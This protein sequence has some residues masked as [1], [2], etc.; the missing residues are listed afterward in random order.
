MQKQ[1]RQGNR[2]L[3]S[4]KKKTNTLVLVVFLGGVSLAFVM[5]FGGLMPSSAIIDDE[6]LRT[7]LESSPPERLAMTDAIEFFDRRLEKN[8]RDPVPLNELVSS[9]FLRFK[10]YGRIQDLRLAK[11]YLGELM[12]KEPSKSLH[13]V[14]LSS[15]YL[16][17]HLFQDAVRA[18]DR[19]IDLA[20]DKR[21]DAAYLQLF[22][23]FFASGRYEEAHDLLE[24]DHLNSNTF[25]YQASYA[26]LQDKLGNVER[27]KASMEKALHQAR[28][29]AQP[30]P[31]IGWCLIELEHLE[32]HSGNAGKAAERYIEALKLLPG[33]PAAL[34]GIAWICYAV[35]VNVS[36]AR[37][38]YQKVLDNGGELDMYLR[39]VEIDEGLGYKGNADKYRKFFVQQATENPLTVRLY[40]RPLALLLAERSESRSRALKY[41]MLDLEN[42]SDSEA[43][44]VLS[45]VLYQMGNLQAA[46]EAS[47]KALAWG[48]PEPVCLY[49]A[50]MILLKLGHT[51]KARNLL[52]E[53]L[54]SSLELGPVTAERCRRAL[55]SL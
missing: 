33:H 21:N 5:H 3:G 15:I 9:Y 17:E 6:T 51:R 29:F 37:R 4:S 8:P 43:Y 47:R 13:Y 7:A 44:D 19:A 49:R 41:A 30:A 36:A 35:D 50:G 27:A 22:D 46:Y 40:Y 32:L 42:R 16:S 11:K 34:E 24:T 53:A 1:L 31:V 10:A 20:G 25:G 52:S 2:R 55:D 38:L 12:E 18:A 39:L 28:A 26:R 23:A 48:E 45:W 14:T 54:E